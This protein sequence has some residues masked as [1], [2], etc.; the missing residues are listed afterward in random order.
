MSFARLLS[1]QGVSESGMKQKKP[2]HLKGV[3]VIGV[4]IKQAIFQLL[5]VPT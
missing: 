2:R 1:Q 5:A 3:V 4:V